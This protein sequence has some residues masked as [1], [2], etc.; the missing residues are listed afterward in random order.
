MTTAT[1]CGL[2][3]ETRLAGSVSNGA[4]FLT[5]PAHSVRVIPPL[6]IQRAIVDRA[7]RALCSTEK[8][9]FMIA[10]VPSESTTSTRV[11]RIQKKS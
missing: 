8:P 4:S 10:I 11:P 9:L 7:T 1:Q 3:L 6:L 5:Q 2:S